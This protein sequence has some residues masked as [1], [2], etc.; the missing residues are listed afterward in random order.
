MKVKIRKKMKLLISIYLSLFFPCFIMA[1]SDP[2]VSTLMQYEQAPI[3]L[4]IGLQRV[5]VPFVSLPTRNKEITCDVSLNYHPLNG[6]YGNEVKSNCGIGWNLFAGGVVSRTLIG[7]NDAS[8][9]NSPISTITGD[10]IYQ[11]NFMGYFGRFILTKKPDGTL[12]VKV[13]KQK[14]SN[15]AL[16]IEKDSHYEVTKFTFFDEKGFQYVF[17][18]INNNNFYNSAYY[19]SSVVDNNNKELVHF[20]YQTITAPVTFGPSGAVPGYYINQ[21][22]EINSIGYG[23]ITVNY[24]NVGLNARISDLVLSDSFNRGIKKMKLFGTP[25]KIFKIQL[26][27]VAETKK[28]TYEFF[29]NNWSN[30]STIATD[31]FGYKTSGSCGAF[32]NGPYGIP[33]SNAA[34]LGLLVKMKLPTG[35]SIIYDYEANTY[36]KYVKD[37]NNIWIHDT[38]PNSYYDRLPVNP[39]V[40]LIPENFIMTDYGYGSNSYPFNFTNDT[41]TF[42]FTVTGSTNKT[43]F[44]NLHGQE[45][46]LP[47]LPHQTIGDPSRDRIPTF[48][49][50]RLT[51]SYTIP[52]FNET[53][54]FED[55]KSGFCYQQMI[56][57]E[58]G[59]YQ[60]T[61]SSDH[62]LYNFGTLE[63]KSQEPNPN[64]T[65][66]FYGGGIR[67]KQVGFFDSD[68]PINYYDLNYISDYINQGYI[69]VKEKKYY[70]NFFGSPISSG[71][72]SNTD[73][74]IINE[75]DGSLGYSKMYFGGYKNVTVTDS[76][77]NGKEEYTFK[78]GLDYIDFDSVN[79]GIVFENSKSGSL[80]SK[81]TYDSNNV[82]LNSVNF[83]YDFDCSEND[84]GLSS[85]YPYSSLSNSYP[86]IF[87]PNP[88]SPTITSNL[89][90]IGKI[91][92][93]TTTDYFSN[94]QN[95][96]VK[97]YFSY[98]AT[99]HQ[100]IE[101]LTSNSLGEIL[102]TEYTYD[103][104]NSIYSQNRISEPSQTKM[105]RSG[106]L[107]STNKINY[108]NYSTNL[109]F[110]PQTVEFAR[111]SGYSEIRKRYNLYDE[112]SNLIE[113][114]DENGIITSYI[115]GY[116]NTVIVAKLN[117]I[118]VSN[119]PANIIDAIHSTTDS[120]SST[121]A[122]V[123]NALEALRSSADMNLQKAMITTYAY[124]PLIG[125][126]TITD[127]RGSKT[128]YEYD[129]LNRL[130]RVR[131]KNNNILSETH[132]NLTNQN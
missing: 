131:D 105:Y 88:S 83:N 21:I 9:F 118:A 19:L 18:I 16:K 89:I 71:Y 54:Y 65:K 33:T 22:K 69:P 45:Y 41:T 10:D 106:Y 75:D 2:T 97:E 132:Y 99:Y 17:D 13:M 76:Q 130:I 64:P 102:R 103:T 44:F 53:G 14:D 93:K 43:L 5:S 61:I 62:S 108:S 100:L 115:W 36:T 35:G 116:N 29:Y 59:N 1:Q 48:T 96:V 15:L 122:D 109:S 101:H 6:V 42:N 60:I 98:D 79:P 4:S 129:E 30:S 63:I 55:T 23:K 117:N 37:A 57:L 78:D 27:D 80:L 94:G 123:T 24:Y 110:L 113:E 104:N 38:D 25:G 119:I 125:I 70:Y 68:A 90:E 26:T 28:E 34:F 11:F 74:S 111:G 92:Q 47:P 126:S 85:T 124:K 84:G 51:G 87:T 46:S 32:Q 49:L 86:S 20:T 81:K 7:G 114:Q 50:K 67:I 95:K 73:F 77:N 112:F 12:V 8:A 31:L 39:Q 3:D 58:P 120:F 127:I 52:H 121:E 40:P 56:D 66:W 82:L 72:L 107:I 128:T 91:T